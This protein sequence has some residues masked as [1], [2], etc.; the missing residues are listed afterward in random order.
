MKISNDHKDIIV[1][2]NKIVFCLVSRA[3]YDEQNN[4]NRRSSSTGMSSLPSRSFR[5][6]Q[7]QYNT[8]TPM[9]TTAVED[10][11]ITTPNHNNGLR[12]SSDAHTPSRSFKFLQDQYPVS[13]NPSQ[14]VNNRD[15]LIEIYN[16]RKNYSRFFF[17]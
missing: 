8:D 16:K 10:E 7:E 17:F 4:T 3:I 14:A 5:Y 2:T 9:V 1:F 6:L 11:I 13:A 12:R 15:D